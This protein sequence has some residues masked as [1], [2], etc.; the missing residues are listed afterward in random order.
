MEEC[1]QK[2]NDALMKCLPARARF[3]SYGWNHNP[4]PKE[5]SIIGY[6]KIPAKDADQVLLQSG[7][8]SAFF[9]VMQTDVDKENTKTKIRWLERGEQ[10]AG[11]YL[12]QA[13]VTA[14]TEGTGIVL[15]RGGRNN[16]GPLGMDSGLDFN[17]LRRRW[18]V[19]G[20]P[21]TWD[22]KQPQDLM[23]K[24]DFCTVGDILAPSH[25]TGIWTF[26][27]AWA[28]SNNADCKIIDLDN[29]RNLVITP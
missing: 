14:K 11:S 26:K 10:K 4:T 18:A 27:A 12:A 13:R 21:H 22:P 1:L 19:R 24:H 8:Q 9:Q 5:E 7:R 29:G 28:G 20:V 6:F 17:V 15:R 3:R 16:S 25:K 2:P 23:E